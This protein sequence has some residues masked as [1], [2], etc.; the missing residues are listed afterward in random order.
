MEL[1]QKILHK[2]DGMQYNQ[3]YLCLPW[4]QHKNDTPRLNRKAL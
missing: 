1:I 4:E 2:F 3:E